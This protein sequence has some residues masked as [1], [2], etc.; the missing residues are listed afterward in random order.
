MYMAQASVN[1]MA[2]MRTSFG[3][4]LYGIAFGELE[5]REKVKL[6]GTSHYWEVQCRIWAL[7]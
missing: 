6:H 1:L 3:P 2:K 7:S 5:S 4:D